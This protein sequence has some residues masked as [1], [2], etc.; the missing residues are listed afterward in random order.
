MNDETWSLVVEAA[1]STGSRVGPPG[2]GLARDP[3]G[4]WRAE[5][6]RPGDDPRLLAAILRVVSLDVCVVVHLAQSLDGRIALDDG[7]SRWISGD[8]DLDHTHRLRAVC[9]AVIVGTRT[10]ALDDPMLTV[11]RCAGPNPVRVVI[12]P[13]RRL[14]A[15]LQ[16][17][18]DGSAPTWR[19]CA[20]GAAA[21]PND[22][23]V[24]PRDG[25]F[26][27]DDLVAAL[28]ARGIRRILVEGG[29][30]TASR[31]VAAGCVDRLHLVVAPVLVGAGRSGLSLASWSAGS[32]DACPRPPT[33]ACALGEDWL[34]DC[35]LS[36]SRG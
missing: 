14:R 23:V 4:A 34:F 12:D 26:P 3:L 6:E 15:D 24:A 21:D 10:V 31:F 2:A 16:V 9:D 22:V 8:A 33:D 19:V 11:R 17:F 13:Q 27:P 5:R 1:R 20:P 25:V 35:D 30:V 28:R 32:L 7:R 18:T 36:R 29:G